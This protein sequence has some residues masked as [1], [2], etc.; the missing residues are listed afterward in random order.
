MSAP[1]RLPSAAEPLPS[2][3]EPLPSAA[4]PVP[5]EAAPTG[6]PDRP[7]EPAKSTPDTSVA[8]PAEAPPATDPALAAP[9]QAAPPPASPAAG[10]G[11][12]HPYRTP[13]MPQELV[14]FR[15]TSRA[16]WPVIGP[17]LSVF[18]VLLWTFVVAGQ[19][20]TSWTTGRPLPQGLALTAV[21][22]GTLATWF[23]SVRRSH[24]AAPAASSLRMV[25][26][27]LGV[28]A[29]SFLS[30]VVTLVAVTTLASG[31]RSRDQDFF[32]AC[33]LVLCSLVAA[34]LGA[35]LTSPT[36]PART[37]SQR[38][39]RVTMWVFGVLLTLAA[40]VDLAANG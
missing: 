9:A 24:I 19:F 13:E 21:V 23:V 34:L 18:A 29:L 7:E 8:P 17:T 16:P 15:Q 2:A 38:F 1:E 27:A 5:P 25:G 32:I 10:P 35:R 14:D 37:H 30:F 31:S 22:F 4:D 12:P 11:A 26:R 20:T 36:P 39:V 28:G 6:P 3:P 40:G 33:A